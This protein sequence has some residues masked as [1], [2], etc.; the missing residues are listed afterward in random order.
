MKNKK[1][2][3]GI[4]FF[5]VLALLAGG[6]M[7]VQAAAETDS[8]V[9]AFFGKGRQANEALM[10]R[11]EGDQAGFM[12][13]RAGGQINL[14]AEEKAELEAKREANR[15]EALAR[16]EAA[17]SA[18]K[19]GDYQAWKLAVGE[20]HPWAEKITADNFARFVEAHNL[21]LEADEIFAEL[22]LEARMGPKSGNLMLGQ[23]MKFRLAE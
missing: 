8:G 16:H 5:S 7:A 11:A 14:S 6:V 17:L 18:V 23:K 1:L 2:I 22:G 4:G 3:Q 9:R 13:M 15:T 20:D 10:L 21:R 12:K 19:A